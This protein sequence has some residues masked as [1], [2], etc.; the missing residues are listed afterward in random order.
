MPRADEHAAIL[1]EWQAKNQKRP[2]PRRPDLAQPLLDAVVGP[3]GSTGA[4]TA[5]AIL[6]V[7]PLLL[8]LHIGALDEHLLQ[9]ARVVNDRLKALEVI[10]EL[11]AASRLHVGD[12]VRLGHNL[13]PQ[14]LH[15]R[16][17]TVIAK[18]GEKWIVRLVEPV[19]R[20]VDGDL[21][22]WA[23]QL[24]PIEAPDT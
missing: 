12:R 17:A 10:E 7:A 6:D 24:E 21:R 19:G 14:Y 22:V 8:A 23:A 2:V 16:S 1:H 5:S 15:G 13:R 20:F 3:R 4:R 11:M 18:D 9:I